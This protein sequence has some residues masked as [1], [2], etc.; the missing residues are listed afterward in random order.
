[1]KEIIEHHCCR[2]CGGTDLVEVFNLGDQY[3]NDF[4]ESEKVK[5]GVI[6]PLVLMFCEGCT[7][8]QLKHTAPQEL[9]YSG[10]YWYR[11]GVTKTMRDA[12]K[13][14][15]SS[16]TKRLW[17]LKRQMMSPTSRAFNSSPTVTTRRT[18]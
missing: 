7:L 8:L 6:A 2:L 15:A 16:A 17:R 11:S 4:V 14:V 12:L 1:M 5:S 9:L 3:V 18:R 10:F 13:N